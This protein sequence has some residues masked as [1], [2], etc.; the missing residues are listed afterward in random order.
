[1]TQIIQ[2]TEKEMNSLVKLMKELAEYEKLNP[3]DEEAI[4]RLSRDLGKRY[5]AYLANLK[6]NNVGYSIL[7]EKYSSFNAQ[8]VLYLHDLFVLKDYR[9]QGV[10]KELFLHAVREA[11]VRGCCRME[12]EVLRWNEPALRFYEKTGATRLDNWISYKLEEEDI[13]RL[14]ERA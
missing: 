12:W 1:M 10:G 8:P 13:K 6:G 7:I 3:P 2:T 5:D 14:T 4:I 11:N 9:K